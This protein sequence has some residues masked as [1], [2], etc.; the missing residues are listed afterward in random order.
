MLSYTQYNNNDAIIYLLLAGWR[1]LKPKY[2]LNDVRALIENTSV[3]DH[4]YGGPRALVPV[5]KHVQVTYKEAKQ[6]I[7]NHLSKL[8]LDNFSHSILI[9]GVVYDVY[10]KRINGISW[11][12]KFSILKDDKGSFLYSI[13]FHPCEKELKTRCGALAEYKE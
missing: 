12:I 11:Y 13:S 2:D 8:T 9:R 10:G 6:F 5:V 1:N 7:L 3:N 4:K